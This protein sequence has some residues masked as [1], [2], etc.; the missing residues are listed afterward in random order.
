MLSPVKC[1]LLEYRTLL[2]KMYYD[3]SVKHAL[4]A[5][6]VNYKLMVDINYL[7]TLATMIP[8]L[9]VVKALV[10]FARSLVFIYVIS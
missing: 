8:L 6:K 7:L 1:V 10:I 9:K 3:Q 4:L 5:T 2:V